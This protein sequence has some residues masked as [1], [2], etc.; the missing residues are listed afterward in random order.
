MNE[1]KMWTYEYFRVAE[2]FDFPEKAG[3][4]VYKSQ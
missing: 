4:N 1:T 2:S 3:Y